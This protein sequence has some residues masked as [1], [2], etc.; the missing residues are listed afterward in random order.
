MQDA[1]FKSDLGK[2]YSKEK[3]AKKEGKEMKYTENQLNHIDTDSSF[4]IKW[5][6]AH[7]CKL[8]IKLDIENDLIRDFETVTASQHDAAIEQIEKIQ[9]LTGIR[10]T[11]ELISQRA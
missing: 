11:L 4:S 6:G 10:G 9:P 5:R 1:A 8:S 2:R 3:K 7:E